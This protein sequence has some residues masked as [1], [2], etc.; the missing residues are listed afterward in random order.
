MFPEDAARPSVPQESCPH[1]VPYP[2]IDGTQLLSLLW[3]LLSPFMLPCAPWQG[4]RDQGPTPV[5]GSPSLS[6]SLPS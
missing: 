3:T 1:L 6:P 2:I 5:P 4:A